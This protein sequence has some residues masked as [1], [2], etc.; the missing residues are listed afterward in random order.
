M[1]IIF[2]QLAVTAVQSRCM[3]LPFPQ[4]TTDILGLGAWG[5]EEGVVR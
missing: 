5:G 3:S 1:G 2:L 4:F